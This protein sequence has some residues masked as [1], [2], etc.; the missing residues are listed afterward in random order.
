MAI[1]LNKLRKEYEE[2][3]STGSTKSNDQNDYYKVEEGTHYVRILPWKNDEQE[4]YASTKLHY[5]PTEPVFDPNAKVKVKPV[6]CR[7]VHGEECPMCELYY[8]LWKED[9]GYGSDLHKMYAR[10]IKP[11][12]RFYMNIFDRDTDAVKILSMGKNLFNQIVGVILDPDFGE[13]FIDL[14]KGNDFKLNMYIDSW[15]KYDRSGPRPKS[16]PVG[17]GQLIAAIPEMLHDIHAISKLEDYDE[18]KQ[19][20]DNIISFMSGSNAAA[21]DDDRDDYLEKLQS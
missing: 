12:E 15:P 19:L 11:N 21:E 10:K 3:N 20:R 17:D 18:V 9:R 2:L 7:R 5:V 8:D 14:E 1:D 16:E 13:Q 6:H 4:F